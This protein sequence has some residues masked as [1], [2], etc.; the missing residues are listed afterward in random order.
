MAEGAQ[1]SPAAS[2]PGLM[3]PPVGG[4]PPGA[5]PVLRLP[6]CWGCGAGDGTAGSGRAGAGVPRLK[7]A[8]KGDFTPNVP[9][10]SF[11]LAWRVCQTWAGDR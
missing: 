7:P 5:A 2:W 11:K 10:F 4:L 6:R 9:F 3:F 1:G 8:A